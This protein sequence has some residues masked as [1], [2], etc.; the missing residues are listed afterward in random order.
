LAEISYAA[1]GICFDASRAVAESQEYKSGRVDSFEEYVW[2]ARHLIHMIEVMQN[3]GDFK[4]LRT[5]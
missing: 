4:G 2:Q 1:A 3:S 5:P